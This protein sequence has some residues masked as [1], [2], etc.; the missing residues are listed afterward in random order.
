MSIFNR[1]F[2]REE[3]Q[4]KDTNQKIEKLLDKKRAK[5]EIKEKIDLDYRKKLDSQVKV[6]RMVDELG[7]GALPFLLK[8]MKESDIELAHTAYYG[9][10]F[11]LEP[12]KKKNPEKFHREFKPIIEHSVDVIK[13]A[14]TNSKLH[15][16][17]HVSFAITTLDLYGDKSMIPLLQEILDKVEYNINTIDEQGNHEYVNL[18]G[19]WIN[20]SNIEG[21]QRNRGDRVLI[22]DAI[23]HIQNRTPHNNTATAISEDQNKENIW[24][25]AVSA[26]KS[27][28]FQSF[29]Q[30]I[31]EPYPDDLD[32]QSIVQKIVDLFDFVIDLH[33]REHKGYH[34]NEAEDKKVE[35]IKNKLRDIGFYLWEHGGE[36]RMSRILD[37][38]R[39][40]IGRV[41]ARLLEMW[42]NGIGTWL[43]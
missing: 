6:H 34:R 13:N 7:F 25:A 22:K 26:Y 11:A 43:G 21:E 30:T 2:R 40:R 19:E 20:L 10:W 9:S 18:T 4:K 32:D 1:I 14:Y 36:A 33:T 27:G 23:A 38:V 17:K 41:D 15:Y 5:S 3:S 35:E 24:D 16:P 8:G 12:L 39:N 29:Y 28:D 37:L 42:W 31:D